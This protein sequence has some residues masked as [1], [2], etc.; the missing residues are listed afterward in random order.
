M[1]KLLLSTSVL[2]LLFLSACKKENTVVETTD[3]VTEA[4]IVSGT[5]VTDST[6]SV[7][8]WVG[9][10]PLG[11]HTGTLALKDGSLNIE[12]GKIASGTFTL[13]LNTITVTDLEGDDKAK[14]E[15]HL[16]GLADKKEDQDHFFNTKM[17]PTGTFTIKKVEDAE[18]KTNVTGDL[19]LKGITNEVTF[20]AAV[21]VSD[22]EVSLTSE[23]FKIDRTKWNIN[24]ASKSKMP[25][26]GDKFI[27]DEMEV[28]V[29]LKATK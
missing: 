4:P 11:K 27:D 14:L 25:N 22:N 21:T 10:K 15:A 9:S 23:P 3:V 18:G 17:Y 28:V 29:K 8:E 16:K 26:L 5:F 6:S 19:T 1:K 24:Y 20:L 12:N 13:D 7:V 2:A